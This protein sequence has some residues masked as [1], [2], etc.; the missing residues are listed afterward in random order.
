M[1]FEFLS[2]GAVAPG[3]IGAISLLVALYALNLLPI[4]HAGAGRRVKANVV[5]ALVQLQPIAVEFDFM[6][7]LIACKVA[8]QG[9]I[10][11][12]IRSPRAPSSCKPAGIVL[13]D[14]LAR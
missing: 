2:P 14:V 11:L 4:N 6:K 12:G 10:N 1:I 8:R 9:S 5:F 7:P 13:R 3:L